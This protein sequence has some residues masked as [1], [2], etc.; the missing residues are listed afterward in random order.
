MPGNPIVPSDGSA[1]SIDVIAQENGVGLVIGFDFDGKPAT[2]TLSLDRPDSRIL[3]S[4]ILAA[5]G[6]ATERTFP[7]PSTSGG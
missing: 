4:A 3:A 7:K 1:W 6:D 2:L 5:G